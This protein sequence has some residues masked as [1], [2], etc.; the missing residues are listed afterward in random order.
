V[1]T[2]K[3]AEGLD[4]SDGKHLMLADDPARFI[5]STLR[6]L[7]DPGLRDTVISNGRSLVEARYNWE[8]IGECFVQLIEGLGNGI[9]C[10]ALHV[11]AGSS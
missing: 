9:A 8:A 7:Q 6:I 4:V 2:R 1:A 10:Q 5:E 11:S 3:G